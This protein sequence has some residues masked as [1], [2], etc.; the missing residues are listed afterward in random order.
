MNLRSW[1]LIGALAGSLAGMGWL[2]LE[3]RS[4]RAELADARPDGS[5]RVTSKAAPIPVIPATEPS[6]LAAGRSQ[7]DEDKPAPGSRFDQGRDRPTPPEEPAEETR[8]QRRMRRQAEITA[9]FG[10]FDDESAEEYRARM[11]PFVDMALSGPRERLLDARRAAEEAAGVTDD[12][13][14]QLDTAFQDAYNEALDLTNRSV[15]SGELTPY[16]RNWSGAL[17]VAGG[18]GAILEGTE[19]R[20]GA[21]LTADQMGIIYEQGFEWGEY[22]GVSVPWEQLDAPPPPP[23]E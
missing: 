12:Q 8:E 6:A 5:P 9:I 23:G 4:L 17:N 18:L 15:Q 21:I 7:P 2:Y 10:R 1:L 19:S 16:S 11:V 14:T 20:I 13:R 22:L 3:N